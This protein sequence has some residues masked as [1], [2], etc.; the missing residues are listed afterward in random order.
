MKRK[1][2]MNPQITDAFFLCAGVI[3][4]GLVL[5]G[6]HLGMRTSVPTPAIPAFY[7]VFGCLGLLAS[8]VALAC[9]A[10]H[11]VIIGTFVSALM[12]GFAGGLAAAK[13]KKG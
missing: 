7:D 2:P 6:I 3:A 10:S 9:G 13:G 8:I 4:A 12:I 1:N 5:I 11:V